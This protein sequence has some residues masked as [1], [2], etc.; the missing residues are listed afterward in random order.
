MVFGDKRTPFT[1][2][3]LLLHFLSETFR[4]GYYGVSVVRV[5]MRGD[6]AGL[7][8]SRLGRARLLRSKHGG[9]DFIITDTDTL[10]PP[11]PF[12]FYLLS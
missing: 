3:Q 2:L 8:L 12:P 5:G 6:K 10:S 9:W 11:T 4:L 7:Y 1:P